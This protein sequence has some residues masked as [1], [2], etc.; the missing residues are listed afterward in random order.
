M[1]RTIKISDA[2][3]ITKIYNHYI[4]NTIITFEEVA[5]STQEMENRIKATIPELPWYVFEKNQEVIGYAYASKWKS[6]I[7]YRFSYEISVYLKDGEQS[8]GLGSK[9]Y[10]QLIESLIQQGAKNIIGGVALPNPIS[11]RLH[12]KFGFKKV[13][14]YEKIGVKFG[15]W[16][17]VAYWQLMV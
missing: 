1:I 3:A 4:L 9:L 12:E 15:K 16:L 13:A 14:H 10:A 2:E 6:R 7:G 5:I 8:H 17:D 11:V